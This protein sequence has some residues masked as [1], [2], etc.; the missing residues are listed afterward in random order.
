MKTVDTLI[1]A[2]W[3]VPVEPDGAVYEHHSLAINEGRIVDLLPAGEARAAYRAEVEHDLDQHL[4]MPGLSTPTHTL[5]C[6]CCAAW[7]TTCR[8]MTG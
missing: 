4:L 5:P 1:H 7:P 2:R 8:S 6:H 3:I